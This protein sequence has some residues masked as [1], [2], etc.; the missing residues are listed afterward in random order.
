MF[1]DPPEQEPWSA[2]LGLADNGQTPFALVISEEKG[3]TR[4]AEFPRKRDRSVFA[5][6]SAPSWGIARYVR[7]WVLAIVEAPF[8]QREEDA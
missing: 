4:F 5:E 3:Q 8:W 6:R 7:G 2:V 1:G